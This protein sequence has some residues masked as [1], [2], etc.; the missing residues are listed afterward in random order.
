MR[1]AVGPRSAGGSS[2]CPKKVVFYGTKQS[3]DFLQRLVY[4]VFSP[5]YEFLEHC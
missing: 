3:N 5:N 1:E 4:V 2:T